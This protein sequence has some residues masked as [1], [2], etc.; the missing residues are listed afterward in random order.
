M[1]ENI[2]E[3]KE[4]L[5]P[6]V[7]QNWDEDYIPTIQDAMDYIADCE[8]KGIRPKKSPLVPILVGAGIAVTLIFFVIF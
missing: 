4:N 7:G 1:M 8:S 6:S 2:M 5:K 3:N